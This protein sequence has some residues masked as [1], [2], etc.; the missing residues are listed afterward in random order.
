MLRVN[1]AKTTGLLKAEGIRLETEYPIAVES[2]DHRYPHGT[3]HDNTR[4]P[5]FVE[6]CEKLLAPRSKLAFLDLGCSGG[7]MVL[8][9]ALRGHLSVGLE[10]SDASLA[11]Q[12]AEWRLLPDN[13]K[14]CDITKPFFVKDKNGD[15]QQFDIITAWEVMEHIA[16]KDLPQLFANIHEHLSSDGLFV[17]SIANWEDIDPDSG[18]NWHVTM[19]DYDWWNARLENAQFEVCSEL[20]DIFDL[21]RGGY[22]PPNCYENPYG[23]V[24]TEKCFH[25]VARKV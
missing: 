13:L 15:V 2:L 10:G 12:R 24:N 19:H 8:D 6:R 23:E 17:A 20:L 14:T 9:A 16:E 1:E 3:T 25:I 11:A 18:V 4:Y 7:G 21:A 22:N 5:R